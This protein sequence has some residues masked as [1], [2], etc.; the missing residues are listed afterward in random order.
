MDEKGAKAGEAGNDPGEATQAVV[1]EDEGTQLVELP[2]LIRNGLQLVTSE[3][4]NLE[5]VK[6]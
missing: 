5:A 6:T 3:V 2:Q 4:Q 1:A